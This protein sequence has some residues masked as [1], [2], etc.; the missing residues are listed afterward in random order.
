MAMFVGILVL[1]MVFVSCGGAEAKLVG[2]W[3][4]DG[5]ALVLSKDGTGS[6][7]GATLTWKIE[8][9]RLKM[10]WRSTLYQ[11]DYKLSGTTLTLT[12]VGGNDGGSIYTYIKK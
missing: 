3:E 8:D 11:Y 12:D 6:W 5:Q 10:N 1:G 4:G 7:Y 2:T 9:K